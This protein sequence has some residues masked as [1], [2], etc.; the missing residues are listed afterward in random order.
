MCST[1]SAPPGAAGW[2][3]PQA[4]APSAKPATAITL[5][6]RQFRVQPVMELSNDVLLRHDHSAHMRPGLEPLLIELAHLRVLRHH[7]VGEI[8][9]VVQ[10]EARIRERLRREQILDAQFGSL[11]AQG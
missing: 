2:R 8:H 9:D 10:T 7:A 11:R 4:V 3:S 1:C 6:A 5:Y